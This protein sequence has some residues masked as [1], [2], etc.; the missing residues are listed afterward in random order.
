M[1]HG[2]LIQLLLMLVVAIVAIAVFK[3]LGLPPILAYLATGVI[4]GPMGFHWFTQ[5]QMHSVAELGIVLLMFSLGLEFSW[6]RLWAMRKTVFGVGSFQVAITAGIASALSLFLGFDGP[7]S[8][9]IGGA[10]ALS[11]T[12]I[13]LQM[14]N[15]QGWL[16]K[17]HGEMS[18]SILLFQDIAVV[19]LLILIPLLSPN[20]GDFAFGPAMVSVL[21]GSAA[22]VIILLVGKKLLPLLFDE[23]ARARTNEL[24]VLSTL[25]V[26]ILTGVLTHW[27]GLSMALGAFVAGMLLG[28]SQYKAQLEADIRPFRDLLMG[29]FFMSIGMLL[30]LSIVWQNLGYILLALVLVLLL[31][32]LIV[33]ALFKLAGESWQDSLSAAFCLA[34]VGE[35]SFVVIALAVKDDL[36]SDEFSTALVAIAVL[37]MALSPWLVRNSVWLAKQILGKTNRKYDTHDDFDHVALM[38]KHVVICGYG[39]VG[40]VIARFLRTEAVDYVA[41]DLDPIRVRETR[42]GGE[43][44]IYGD[45]TKRAMLKRAG[46]QQARMMVVTFTDS[47]GVEDLMG[48]ARSIAPDLHIMVRTRDDENMDLLNERGA[49]QVVPETLE[50]S[51]MLVSQVLHQCGVPIT[52]ILKR[53]ERE[54]RAHYRHL[55]GFFSGDA[56]DLTLDHMHAIAITSGS[57]AV[58]KTLAELELERF[59]VEVRGVR[60]GRQEHE[61]VDKEWQCQIGDILLLVGK[62]R[63]VERA[64]KFVHLG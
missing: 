58:G 44:V 51:L 37:S 31:K 45:A 50:G 36:L 2:F 12:A 62:P 27:L 6:P 56:M 64:E 59:R 57:E 60:R 25:V 47:K 8:V 26:A 29:L 42:A 63:R 33:L 15:D 3:R 48:L 4:A 13:V 35:F 43:K 61:D 28:E 46:I 39:R 34:Q 18:V 40:Q 30:D 52:R 22:M 19:P 11:S 55:H 41:L 17:R 20:A 32:A 7:A 49:D 21:Q 24:F 14:L 9:V 16:N 5:Q 53:L 54:R 1:E 38:N 23:V 10:I